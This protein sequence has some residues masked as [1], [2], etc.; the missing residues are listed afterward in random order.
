MAIALA[1]LF[2]LFSSVSYG[3]SS[4]LQAR[5]AYSTSS[6]GRKGIHLF[7]SLLRKPMYLCALAFGGAAFAAQI[8]PLRTLPLVIVQTAQTANL[9]ATAIIAV[10]VLRIHVTMH[11][12]LTHSG[13]NN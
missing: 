4:V 8:Y 2:L 10:I 9:A 11:E 6:Q 5:A 3:A 1:L 13:N 12:W 7:I